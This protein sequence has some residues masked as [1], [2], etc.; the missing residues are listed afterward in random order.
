MKVILHN[1]TL[2]PEQLFTD[3]ADLFDARKKLADRKTKY[4]MH[5]WWFPQH[6]TSIP[7]EYIAFLKIGVKVQLQVNQHPE[8]TKKIQEEIL[9]SFADW[10][11]VWSCWFSRVWFER[12]ISNPHSDIEQLLLHWT[13]D[14]LD[15][16]HQYIDSL[17][18]QLII[19]I[20]L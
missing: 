14:D 15:T 18:A 19:Y 3:V 4:L 20:I 2:L 17:P 1:S 5:Q 16:V 6:W 9:S 7:K 8:I 11:S 10:P 12:E 13:I